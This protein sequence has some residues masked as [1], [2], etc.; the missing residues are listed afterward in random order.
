MPTFSFHGLKRIIQIYL[1]LVTALDPT[2]DEKGSAAQEDIRFSA[3]NA[4]HHG[5]QGHGEGKLTLTRIDLP[6]HSCWTH[7]SWLI[8]LRYVVTLVTVVTHSSIR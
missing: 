3:H 4:N 6:K 8:P 1:P 2:G 5:R 7:W